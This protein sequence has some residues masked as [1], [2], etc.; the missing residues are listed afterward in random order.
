V[1][2]AAV[3]RNSYID[4][5]AKSSGDYAHDTCARAQLLDAAAPP[6]VTNSPQDTALLDSLAEM[7]ATAQKSNNS[8][9]VAAV[10]RVM[11]AQQNLDSE[12]QQHFPP[13]LIQTYLAYRSAQIRSLQ[14]Y[15][16]VHG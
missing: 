1:C 8:G 13:N 11:T 16:M 12:N 5:V 6:P 2:W 10:G 9:L 3:G 15:C 4:V 14:T 7:T